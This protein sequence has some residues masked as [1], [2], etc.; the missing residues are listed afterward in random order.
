MM[1]MLFINI[2]RFSC[3]FIYWLLYWFNY[4]Y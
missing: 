2:F 1:E 3:V 4:L